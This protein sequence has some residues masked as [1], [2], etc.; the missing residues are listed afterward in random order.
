MDNQTPFFKPKVVQ[1]STVKIE[2]GATK[3]YKS[4]VFSIILV[5]V[6]L[7]IMLLVYIKVKDTA[8][9][10]IIQTETSE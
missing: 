6:S 5:L 1:K 8:P 2:S 10:V 7:I 4:L 3:L 9:K